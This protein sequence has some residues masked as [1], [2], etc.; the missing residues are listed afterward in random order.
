MAGF[1]TSNNRIKVTQEVTVGSSTVEETSFDTN[2]NMPHIVGTAYLASQTVDFSNMTQSSSY[3]GTDFCSSNTCIGY[4]WT[5]VYVPGYYT[6][7]TQ[8][9]YV[10]GEWNFS[11]D[12]WS[13]SYS[14]TYTPS[15][16][17]STQVLVWVPSEYYREFNTVFDACCVTDYFIYNINGR[18][19]SSTVDLVDLPTDED[20]NP[21]DIDF[22]IV[23][24]SGSRTRNGKDPRFDQTFVT[25]VPPKTFSF[26]G[27]VLLEA[28]AEAG[29]NSWMRRIMSIFVNNSTGKLRLQKKE[30]VRAI[31]RDGYDS[32]F[33]YIGS[34]RSTFSFNL[35]VFFGRFK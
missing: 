2:S 32:A 35:K 4:E 7:E 21:I 1:T 26:Q 20:G 25:G 5:W 17:Y 12:Y 13:S 16:F 19:S 6:Y 10:P 27:S 28:A 22:V 9:V 14:R 11:Y 8:Y 23:Q 31:N 15:Q 30:S 34:S 18:E 24:A 33:P 29:G 3:A